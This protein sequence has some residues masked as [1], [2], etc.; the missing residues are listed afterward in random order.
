MK[1][2]NLGVNN[3]YSTASDTTSVTV[4]LNGAATSMH[5]SVTTNGNG[6]AASD[7]THT[8]LVTAGETISVGFSE[9]NI[10]PYNKITIGL[11]CQ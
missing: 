3:Y 4:Y 1:A 7:T 10:D 9:S 5:A 6:Q 2:L 8:F 11:I